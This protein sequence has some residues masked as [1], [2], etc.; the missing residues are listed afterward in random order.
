MVQDNGHTFQV[1]AGPGSGGIT[2]GGQQ[3]DRVQS[4][5]HRPSEE[6]VRG[7]RYAMVAHLV[8]KNAQGELAVVAL[9]IRKGKANAFLKA[10]FDVPPSG[11]PETSIAGATLDLGNFLPKQQG[12]YS[13]EGSL[14]TP[15]CSE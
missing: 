12:Y 2:V 14:T 5:F 15:P 6:R 9:L 11:T 13:F 4:H 7:Q 3:Y 1:N 10:V 8:H